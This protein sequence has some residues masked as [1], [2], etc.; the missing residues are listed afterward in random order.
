MDALRSALTLL[1]EALTPW[2]DLRSQGDGIRL[3]AHAGGEPVDDPVIRERLERAL[4]ALAGCRRALAALRER[5]EVEDELA[6]GLLGRLLDVGSV[7][8]RPGG[9]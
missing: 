4:A 1:F 3:G 6:P 8:R 7:E 5:L 9:G 2:A